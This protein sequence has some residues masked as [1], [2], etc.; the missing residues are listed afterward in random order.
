M[1]KTFQVTCDKNEKNGTTCDEI[2]KI[3]YL[4]VNYV[5]VCLF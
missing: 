5:F 2:G 4:H 1:P 3:K